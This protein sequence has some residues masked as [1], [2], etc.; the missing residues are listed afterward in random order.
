MQGLRLYWCVTHDTQIE[1]GIKQLLFKLCV[2]PAQWIYFNCVYRV[3][4]SIEG[5]EYLDTTVLKA[6]M[7]SG[8][9]YTHKIVDTFRNPFRV[10][11][12]RPGRHVPHSTNKRDSYRLSSSSF[13]MYLSR[14]CG[15]DHQFPSPRLSF[16]TS[17]L[18]G[19]VSLNSV[20]DFMNIPIL[21]N[22]PFRRPFR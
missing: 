21:T 4:P 22:N 12:S 15:Q 11:Q 20:L 3:V 18:P 19:G 14:A 1:S 16:S 5:S 10:A 9:F 13:L 6:N 2:P 17:S 7:F 8:V